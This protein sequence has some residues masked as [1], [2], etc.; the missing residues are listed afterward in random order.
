[1]TTTHTF[2]NQKITVETRVYDHQP[3]VLHEELASGKTPKGKSFRIIQNVGA[4]GSIY[5]S[6]KDGHC[7]EIGLRAIMDGILKVVEP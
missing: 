7:Y 1:M 5:V 4:G 6:F 3:L 2:A